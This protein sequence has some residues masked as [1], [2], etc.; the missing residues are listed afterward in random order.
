MHSCLLV[1][2]CVIVPDACNIL[3]KEEVGSAKRVCEKE[4]GSTGISILILGNSIQ[5]LFCKYL[6]MPAAV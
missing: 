2:M 1:A 5:Y 4:S 3:R 6:F